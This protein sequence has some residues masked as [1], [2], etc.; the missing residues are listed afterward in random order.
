LIAKKRHYVANL[1]YSYLAQQEIDNACVTARDIVRYHQLPKKSSH[2]ISAFLNRLYQKA[3]S[4][5]SY[6][7]KI[8]KGD[9]NP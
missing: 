1:V 6:I 8:L 9:M 2:S 4:P 7:V 3:G 5:Y